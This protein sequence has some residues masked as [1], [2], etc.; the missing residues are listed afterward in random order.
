MKRLLLLLPLLAAAQTIDAQKH[1]RTQLDESYT[2]NEV[3]WAPRPTHYRPCGEGVQ[4]VDGKARYNRALYGAHTGFRVECS[5][6][7]EFGIYPVSY[8]HLTLPT[9]SA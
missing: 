9:N 5:D 3:T 1:G 2:F 7:P 6:R 4:T 8:T